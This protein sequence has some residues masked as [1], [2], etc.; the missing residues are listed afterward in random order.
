MFASV[1]AD[2]R[3]RSN[4]FHLELISYVLKKKLFPKYCSVGE[5]SLGN[6]AC[7]K[8]WVREDIITVEF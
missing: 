2:S 1:F 7:S 6:L 5:V 4:S 8:V 3:K